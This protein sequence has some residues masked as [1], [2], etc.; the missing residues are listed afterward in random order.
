MGPRLIV[1]QLRGDYA[2]Q[3]FFGGDQNMATRDIDSISVEDI[4]AYPV[5]R[6]VDDREGDETGLE[7]VR[8][9]PCDDL[10]GK[11]VGVQVCL[12][13]GTNVWGI[14]GNFDPTNPKSTQHFVTL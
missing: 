7:P 4:R 3:Q 2:G 10:N 13:D 12:A 9:L 6:F 5:W 11:I 8:K 14:V 1:T